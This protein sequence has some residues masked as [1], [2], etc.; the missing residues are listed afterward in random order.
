MVS[1][2]VSNQ[3]LWLYWEALCYFSGTRGRLGRLTFEVDYTSP[4]RDEDEKTNKQDLATFYFPL[5]F[6]LILIH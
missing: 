5:S 3:S 6:P 2:S 4:G 1:T